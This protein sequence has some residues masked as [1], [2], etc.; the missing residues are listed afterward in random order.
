MGSCASLGRLFFLLLLLR[1]LLLLLLLPLLLLLLRG[2][3]PK[4]WASATAAVPLPSG[5]GLPSLA[6]SS[7]LL[8][9]PDHVLQPFIDASDELAPTHAFCSVSG[10]LLA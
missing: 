7:R 3:W 2:V 4:S 9:L 5:P 1:L 8:F 6:F 10:A